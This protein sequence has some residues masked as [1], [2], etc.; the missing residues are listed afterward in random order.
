VKD[1][2]SELISVWLSQ[3]KGFDN[4]SSLFADAFV[5]LSSNQFL[6]QEKHKSTKNVRNI[7][8]DNFLGPLCFNKLLT[9]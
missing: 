4:K 2:N 6:K 5:H 8:K 1:I 3:E 9:T 7:Y